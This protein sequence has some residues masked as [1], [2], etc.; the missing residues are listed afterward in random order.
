MCIQLVAVYVYLADHPT[1]EVHG[2]D[3]L[4]LGVCEALHVA[5]VLAD[6]RDYLGPPR[7]GGP[8][9]DALPDLDDRVDGGGRSGP[10]GEMEIVALDEVD[11]HPGIGGD[12]V[13]QPY[14]LLPHLGAVLSRGG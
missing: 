14:D 7:L 12:L 6:V 3:Y 10:R 9:A 11:S 4:R 2:D 13:E 1:L 8:S 5:R